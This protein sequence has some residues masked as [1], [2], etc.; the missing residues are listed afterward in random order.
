MELETVLRCNIF[1]LLF[2]RPEGLGV[3]CGAV[4][5]C[6]MFVFMPV[7]FHK[8]LAAN[9]PGKFPHNEVSLL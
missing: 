2:H 7:P 5:L 8:H 4:F 6:V 3:V 9:T 1:S